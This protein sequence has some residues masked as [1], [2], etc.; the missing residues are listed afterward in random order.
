MEHRTFIFCAPSW[1]NQLFGLYSRRDA[2][3]KTTNAQGALA[4]PARNKAKQ[5]VM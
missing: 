2:S 4:M 5:K 1:F 3:A